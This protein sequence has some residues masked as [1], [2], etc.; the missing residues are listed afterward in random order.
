MLIEPNY[1]VLMCSAGLPSCLAVHLGLCRALEAQG[2]DL[3]C[4]YIESQVTPAQAV[5]VLVILVFR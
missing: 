4:K 1:V 3:I 2:N 5:N